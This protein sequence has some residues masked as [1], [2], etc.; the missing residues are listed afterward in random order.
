MLGRSCFAGRKS[1]VNLINYLSVTT[2][3]N[4]YLYI[5]HH[6]ENEHHFELKSIKNEFVDLKNLFKLV[7]HMEILH[8]PRYIHFFIF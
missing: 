1:K 2:L 6:F 7:L 4:I 8:K 3:V 5:G